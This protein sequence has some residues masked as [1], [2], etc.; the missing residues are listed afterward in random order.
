MSDLFRISE[1]LDDIT[2]LKS[3]LRLKAIFNFLVIIF[4]LLV[5]LNL[6]VQKDYILSG[7]CFIAVLFLLHFQIQIKNAIKEFDELNDNFFET[8]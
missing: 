3:D 1:L 6:L 7:I 8:V 2:A 4:Q 5:L